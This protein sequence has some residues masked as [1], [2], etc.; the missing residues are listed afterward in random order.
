[1]DIINTDRQELIYMLKVFKNYI[2]TLN[3]SRNHF[4]QVTSDFEKD[5]KYKKYRYNSEDYDSEN[6]ICRLIMQYENLKKDINDLYKV[7]LSEECTAD[8]EMMIKA[9]EEYHNQ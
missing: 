5:E 6:D 9:L 4:I 2:L 7:I 3:M 8:F 1:M